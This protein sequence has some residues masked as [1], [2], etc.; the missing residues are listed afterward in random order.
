MTKPQVIRKR[1]SE[2]EVQ[3]LRWA[4]ADSVTADIAK[5][6]GRPVG[7]V[8][9]KARKLG[10]SKG[11]EYLASDRSGRIFKGGKLGVVSQFK[12][13]QV[14]A[15]KGLRHAKGWAPGNMASTQFKA[16]NRPHTWVPVGSLR[17][18]PEGYLE[19]KVND[20]PGN[21]SVRWHPVHRLVWT[22]ANGPVPAG[23]VVVFKPGRRTAELEAITLDAVELITRR[24][25]MARNTVH[26]LHA[27]VLPIVRL[28]AQLTREINRRA[29]EA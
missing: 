16:G 7:Q 27:Q 29:K 17:I 24:E 2:V 15:N 9:A 19:R 3:L 1:W 23:Q 20:L 8:Y 21:S 14:P 11:A 22:D 18:N 25:L 4:Y 12:P 28:R 13:G 6:L 5:A 26:N 10:L